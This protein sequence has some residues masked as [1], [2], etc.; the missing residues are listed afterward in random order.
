MISK[1]RQDS[2]AQMQSL[3][4]N[5]RSVIADPSVKRLVRQDSINSIKQLR[6]ESAQEEEIA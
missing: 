5:H 6:A 3:Q 2:R 4:D 1:Q